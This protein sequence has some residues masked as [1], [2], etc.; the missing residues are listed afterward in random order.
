MN[1]F[2]PSLRALLAGNVFI[3]GYLA[4]LSK[5]N[6]LDLVA[7]HRIT[8]SLCVCGGVCVCWTA[9]SSVFTLGLARAPAWLTIWISAFNRSHPVV[10]REKDRPFQ[11]WNGKNE[12]LFTLKR[13]GWRWSSISNIRLENQLAFILD[14]FVLI[15]RNILIT[16]VQY[17]FQISV[18]EAL[19]PG[20]RY[21]VVKWIWYEEL[22]DE[23]VDHHYKHGICK[24]GISPNSFIHFFPFK[25]PFKKKAISQYESQKSTCTV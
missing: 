19:A 9:P 6:Y 3:V 12:P 7:A 11:K 24:C 4:P 18:S 1:S 25:M 14:A 15:N 2:P 8:F 22:D 21:T 23:E 17:I 20:W 13:S 16:E 5:S 10:F